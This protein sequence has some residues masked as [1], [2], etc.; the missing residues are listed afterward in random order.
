MATLRARPLEDISVVIR[1]MWPPQGLLS[2]DELLEQL[3]KLKSWLDSFRPLSPDVLRELKRVYDVRFTFHSNAIEGSTLTQ[4]ETELIL[5][6]GITVGGKTLVEHLE[7]IGHRDAIDYIEELARTD[8]HIG[9]R[10]IRDLH[11]LILRGVDQ[12]TGR[13]DADRYR[14]LDVRAAGSDHVYPPHYRI[15]ELMGDFC[16]WLNEEASEEDEPMHPV[17]FAT[18]VHYRLV[19]IHPFRDGNGRTARLLMNLMLLRAGYPIAVLTNDRRQTYVDALIHADNNNDIG[20]LTTL[21]AEAS[22]ESLVETL[23]ILSTAE[24]SRG[25][26]LPFYQEM[27][28]Y[29]AFAEQ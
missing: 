7:V 10:E 21:V 1:K 12:I 28:D 26:G 4:S 16:Q 25:K 23:R 20:P 27:L 14:T 2:M 3:D 8:R 9:E 17:I 13:S 5:E 6:K 29:L 19:A 24:S 18:E 15:P 22:R 11:I